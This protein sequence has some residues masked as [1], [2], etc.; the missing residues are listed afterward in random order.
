V[1]DQIG[2]ENSPER[3][4]DAL[5]E[6]FAAVRRVLRADGSLW[7]NLGDAFENKQLLLL[8]SRLAQALQGAGW[9]LRSE[10]VWQ[11]NGLSESVKDR[12]AK[13]HETIYLLTR[14][15]SRYHYDAAAVREPAAT[16]PH[17]PGNR[18]AVRPTDSYTKKPDRI[19]GEDGKRNLRTVWSIPT[20]AQPGHHAAFPA[21]LVERCIRAGCPEGG[22]VLDPFAGVGTTLM[23]A[24]R[25]QRDAIGIELNAD[26]CHAARRRMLRDGGMFAQAALDLTL[27]APASGQMEMFADGGG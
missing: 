21:E 11:K 27:P 12:P 6:V 26:Y 18:I 20:E 16:E 22:T 23:V 10:I 19:W 4:I 1:A 8:P 2:Q 25:L 7:I 13:G 24:D 14:R 5:V 17:A 15:R 3:Y 9:V